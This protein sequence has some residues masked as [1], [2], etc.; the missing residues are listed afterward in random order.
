M[1]FGLT[2]LKWQKVIFMCSLSNCCQTLYFLSTQSFNRDNRHCCYFL[3]DTY[4]CK[5]TGSQVWQV[6][7]ENLMINEAR[8]AWCYFT[9]KATFCLCWANSNSWLS[10]GDQLFKSHAPV[11]NT[12]GLPLHEPFGVPS[13]DNWNKILVQV[14]MASSKSSEN[15]LYCKSLKAAEISGILNTL[16]LI[17][18]HLIKRCSLYILNFVITF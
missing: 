12:L 1:S 17:N 15:K 9:R 6:Q 2:L 18:I 11:S 7:S 13:H 5:I 8:H 4:I 10:Q 14:L 3:G 16:I